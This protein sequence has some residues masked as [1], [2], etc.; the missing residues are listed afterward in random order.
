ME[1]F[2][3]K[4]DE[5]IADEI[6]KD[7][8]KALKKVKKEAKK[9]AKNEV[10][11]C[12]GS[13]NAIE[14]F[15][16]QEECNGDCENC[17]HGHEVKDFLNE[18]A[19]EVKKRRKEIEEMTPE[20][21]ANWLESQHVEYIEKLSKEFDFDFL[22]DKSHEA[23][24]LKLNYMHHLNAFLGVRDI[25]EISDEVKKILKEKGHYKLVELLNVLNY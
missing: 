16:K 11:K 7:L 2:K 25:I 9:E 24:Y 19:K 15:G 8:E 6:K 17:E 4:T 13:V 23:K 22:S 20:K 1:E 21:F 3:M 18:L 14:V 10:G 5:E 12:N